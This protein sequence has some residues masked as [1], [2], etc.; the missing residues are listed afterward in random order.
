MKNRLVLG[1][2]ILAVFLTGAA[3]DRPSPDRYTLESAV[4][5]AV[6]RNPIARALQHDVTGAR[7]DLR[8]ANIQKV[9]PRLNVQLQTGLVPEARGDIFSSPDLQTDLD[10]LG[11]FARFSLE[12]VQPLF[13]F[14][15]AGSAVRMAERGVEAREHRMGDLLQDLAFE[16]V[17]AFWAMTLADRAVE[18]AD[19]SRERYEELLSEVRARLEREDSEVDEIDFLEA[20]S[21]YFDI[22]KLQEDSRESRVLADELFRAL[23]DLDTE[24]GVTLAEETSPRFG[25]GEG[26]L[27]KAVGLAAES[28]EDIMAAESGLQALRAKVDLEKRQR[29]PV[30][31]LAAG[32]RYAHAANR[33]DQTNPFVVDDFNYRSLGATLGLSWAPD[34]LLHRAEV[35]KAAAEFDSAAEKVRSLRR[36]V[37]LAVSRA[38]LEARKKEA[39]LDA[40]RESHEAAK[41]WLRTS[42]DNWDLGIGDAFRLLRAYQAYFRTLRTE[43]E[44]EYDFN[45]S[46]AGLAREL[47]DV[48]FYLRWLEN[49]QV[50]LESTL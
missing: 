48:N 21:Y 12:M 16:T 19:E 25:L 23:L 3:E 11:P 20:K 1:L 40:A 14:G 44:S 29:F 27:D 31:F 34:F 33:Q 9:T 15:Q 26:L 30:V 47:G 42:L 7:M 6:E 28:R 5:T 13:T 10:G 38:F 39:L 24:A 46:L 50:D 45:V 36:Q 8:R 17:K 32:F 22:V 43:I 4:R 2:M 37:R 35:R 18:V 49:G 41:T